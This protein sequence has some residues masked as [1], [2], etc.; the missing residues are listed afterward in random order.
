MLPALN[1][2]PKKFWGEVKAFA[3]KNNMNEILA[4]MYLTIKRAD[5]VDHQ[6]TRNAFV[7]HGKNIQ[8]FKGVKN[9]FNKIN[10]YAN[11]KNILIEHYIISSG[12]KEIIEGTPIKEHFKY[13]YAS[14]FYYDVNG[15]A[16]WPACAVDYTLKTQFLFRVNK[17][18]LEIWDNSNINK[19][20]PEDK[21]YIPFKRMIYIGDG[22]TDIPCM[23]MVNYQGGY[24]IAVYDPNKKKTKTSKS[25]KQLCEELIKQKRAK[26]MAPAVYSENSELVKIVKLIIHKIHLETELEKKT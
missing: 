2:K 1:Q 17:G 6:I 4:Y 18:T 21:R 23:K 15:V 19:Y 11:E 22:E 26:F 20:A 5:Q 3:K 13:I 16:Q 14:E 7:E 9:Y 8:L 12:L 25:P 10:K 24:S